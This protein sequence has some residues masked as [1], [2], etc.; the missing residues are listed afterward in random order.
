M[1]ITLTWRNI[2]CIQ[3]NGMMTSFD[4]QYGQVDGAL[5]TM[6][7]GS[8]D[9]TS[10]IIIALMPLTVYWFQIAWGNINDTGPYTAFIGPL[11]TNE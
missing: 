11:W 1:N 5:A 4:I 8:S 10:C 6:R 3:R 2:N 7:I 9:M